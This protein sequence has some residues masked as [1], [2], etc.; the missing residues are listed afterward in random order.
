MSF[1]L[2]NGN[3]Y[4]PLGLGAGK[5]WKSGGTTYNVFAEPQWTLAHEGD[6]VCPKFQVFFGL[7]MQFPL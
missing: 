1:D 3:Y 4:V 7:N 2:R 6:G 5:I